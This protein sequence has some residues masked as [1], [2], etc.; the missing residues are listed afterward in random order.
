VNG[1]AECGAEKT[2]VECGKKI[3]DIKE[4]RP[5]VEI[6]RDVLER[7]MESKGQQGEVV[8]GEN[9]EDA[10]AVEDPEKSH[11]VSS[12]KENSPNQEAGEH[13]ENRDAQPGD[14]QDEGEWG[15]PKIVTDFGRIV[16][17]VVGEKDGQKGV[18]ANT[19]ERRKVDAL[20][21]GADNLGHESS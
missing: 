2:L 4:L 3:L 19:L 14:P 6:Q 18:S 13:K 17:G 20:V 11:S 1:F 8:D 10:A 5:E 16:G 7:V 12:I 9:A 15:E 21:I